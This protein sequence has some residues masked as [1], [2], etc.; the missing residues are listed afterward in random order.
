MMIPLVDLQAQHQP[1]QAEICRAISDCIDRSSLVGGPDC[2][3]FAEEFAAFC[4]GGHVALCGSGTDALYLTLY[5]LLGPGNGSGEIVTVANTFCATAEAIVIAGYRPV[6]V[7]VRPDTLLMDIDRLERAITPQTKAILPVHL[8]GQMVDMDRVQ[9]IARRHRLRVIEDAA[10][11]HGACWRG[12]GPGMLSDAACFSFYVS[13]NLGALGEGGAVLSQDRDL[14]NHIAQ[15]ANHGA[16]SKYVHDEVGYNS[17]L[18]GLQAAV[19][20]IKLRHLQEWNERRREIA[21]DFDRLL[22]E[23]PYIQCPS[24]SPQGVHVFHLYVV[25]VP[26]REAMVARLHAL[27]IQTGIHYPIPLDLQ[28]AFHSIGRAHEDLT[29]THEAAGEILSLPL[30]PQM[31]RRQVEHVAKAV[32]AAMEQTRADSG[33]A[34]AT[35][36][37]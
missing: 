17:R 4:G 12:R 9:E 18:D 2:A 15:L 22:A 37:S 5:A 34:V 31:T 11:A 20:R 35:G 28:K 21:R 8:Y 6:F 10:Q 13:K 1:I 33:T 16:S 26:N 23:A 14:V 27:G 36:A 25:R 30:Y 7:D 32:M 24:V 29:I 3:A 19:L